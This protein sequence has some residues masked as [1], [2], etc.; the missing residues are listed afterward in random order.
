[1]TITSVGHSFKAAVSL[2]AQAGVQGIETVSTSIGA[3]V[4]EQQNQKVEVYKTQDSDY[5][6][7][8]GSVDGVDHDR[9]E[10]YIITNPEITAQTVVATSQ[11]CY[12]DYKPK[13]P[14]QTTVQVK[15]GV[16]GRQTQPYK[17]FAGWL[18]DPS[19]MPA[20]VAQHLKSNHILPKDYANILKSDP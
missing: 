4:V 12:P 17:L 14:P 19:T 1:G 20:N 7:K 2:T 6:V 5:L 16:T 15:Y 3:T 13:H 9:D 18:R 11:G 8:G 10:I